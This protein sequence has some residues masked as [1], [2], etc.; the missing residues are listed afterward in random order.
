M[1]ILSQILIVTLYVLGII[2][3]IVLITLC[4]KLIET[5]DKANRVID[6]VE[7]KV[8][9]LDGLFTAI[10]RVTDVVSMFSDKITENTLGI[11]SKIKEIASG[12]KKNKKRR[13]K[14]IEEDE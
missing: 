6:D 8:K 7:K 5:V 3:L 9:T 11:L 1:D 2:L 12:K 10:D 4:I 14:E 13:S